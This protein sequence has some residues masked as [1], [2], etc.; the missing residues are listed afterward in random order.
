MMSKMTV[1]NTT[2]STAS[3]TFLSILPN[4][5][6]EDVLKTVLLAVIGAVVSFTLSFVFKILIA[7]YRR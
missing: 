1:S 6:S 5:N 2:L 7:K 4:L 3:G